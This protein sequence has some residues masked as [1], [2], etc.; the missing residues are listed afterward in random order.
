MLAE[1]PALVGRVDDNRIF[2]EAGVVEVL[3]HAAD[4]VVHRLHAAQIILD[5]TLVHP[6]DLGLALQVGL[7]ECLVLRSVGGVPNFLL[8]RRQVVRA[9]V[10]LEIVFGKMPRD[11]HRLVTGG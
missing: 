11:C 4:V 9:F 1:V 3:E 5:V 6:L 8:L 7:A 2:G 10:E